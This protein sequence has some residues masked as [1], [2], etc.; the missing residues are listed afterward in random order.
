MTSTTRLDPL[1][2]YLLRFGDTALV[3]GQQLGAW[4]GHAPILE[5]DLAL[6]NVALDLVGEARA[7]L[8]HAGER[9]GLERDEDA[10]AFSRG[11]REFHNVL[12]VE[13]PN[14]NFA[15]TLGRQ[16]LF[17]AWHVLALEQLSASSDG[18]IAAL[19][20]KV[21]KEAAYHARR[22]ADWVVRLGD[23]TETSKARMQA[24]LAALWP[25]VG[26]LFEGDDVDA[27]MVARGIG[28]DPA[29][30]REPWS[31]GVGAVLAEATLVQPSEGW[32][33][34][35]GKRGLH[36]EHLGYLLAE[37]QSVRRSVPGDLW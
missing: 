20:R 16:F 3:L 26:E 9:E 14:G 7:W 8:S 30:L 4:T 1:I 23:G 35:G 31:R 25:Y 33:Q 32:M 2:E 37:M 29:A 28:F 27:E 22:S 24:A 19:A 11:D 5:E 6:T 17:D 18:R 21:R 36:S 10:L 34:R 12:L 13:R 15:D